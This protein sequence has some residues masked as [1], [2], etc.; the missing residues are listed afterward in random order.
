MNWLDSIK[1]AKGTW[2]KIR[3]LEVRERTLVL[4]DA[5]LDVYERDKRE[6]QSKVVRMIVPGVGQNERRP[7][8]NGVASYWTFIGLDCDVT[9]PP[10]I[11]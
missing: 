2:T 1:R 7:T 6:V 11:L 4:L 8:R 9:W 3:K 10:N 5:A